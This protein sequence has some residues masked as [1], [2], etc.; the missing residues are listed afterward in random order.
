MLNN[1]K[2]NRGFI[3]LFAVTIS[4]ILLA[5]GLGVASITLKEFNFSGIGKKA[6]EAFFAADTGI[7]CALVND[8]FGDRYFVQNP[9]NSPNNQLPCLDATLV[10][11]G[12]WP[13]WTFTVPANI[14]N[15]ANP[16]GCV[17]VTISKDDSTN[18][19]YVDTTVRSQGYNAADASCNPTSTSVERELVTTYSSAGENVA[20]GRP[21]TD[22]GAWPGYSTYPT[23]NA[24]DGNFATMAYPNNTLYN[25][26]V[27]LQA[28][29]TLA[30]INVV[31]CP[32]SLTPGAAV[33]FGF[34][35]DAADQI[36]F[37]GN[38]T[39]QSY[40]TTWSLQGFAGSWSTI[41]SGGTPNTKTI[42]VDAGG[43]TYSKLRFNATS[44]THWIG[45]Y[46]ISAY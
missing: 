9:A 20:L 40:I 13:T 22:P 11:T 26:E 3:I 29:R 2:Q 28:S 46:E 4:S 1:A 42:S 25:L 33:C 32:P 10:L 24:T 16:Q 21:V 14:V 31:L 15:P 39:P 5:I 37:N 45:L 38:D 41:A 12:A 17:K 30:Q 8:Q 44:T 43:N 19:P 36:L 7:E 35:Y 34:P 27:D 18:A 6:N 23:G